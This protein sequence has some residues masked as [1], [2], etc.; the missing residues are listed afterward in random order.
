MSD[1]SLAVK[2]AG[3]LF[4][5]G[6]FRGADSTHVVALVYDLMMTADGRRRLS[7][8]LEALSRDKAFAGSKR[9]ARELA[10]LIA[11]KARAQAVP[12]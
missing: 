10:K 1:G 7:A 9:E 12:A 6:L 8:E 11:P 3:I 2:A 4:D 5:N